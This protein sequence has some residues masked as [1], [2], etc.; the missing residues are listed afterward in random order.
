MQPPAGC[1]DGFL[2][3]LPP[4]AGTGVGWLCPVCPGV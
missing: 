2:A 4:G 3:C 1:G